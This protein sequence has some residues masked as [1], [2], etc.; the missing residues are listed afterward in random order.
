MK[1]P[2]PPDFYLLEWY[3]VT[4]ITIHYLLV[5]RKTEQANRETNLQLYTHIDRN[6]LN[7]ETNYLF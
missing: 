3:I 6:K 2:V 7:L 4:Y 5:Y 1:L